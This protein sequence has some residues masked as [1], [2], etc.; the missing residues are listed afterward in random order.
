METVGTDIELPRTSYLGR[1]L[2]LVQIVSAAPDGGLTLSEL[3]AQSGVPASTA[4]RLARLLEEHGL[5]QRL[6]DKRYVAGPGL[7]TLGLRSLR[8]LPAERFHDAVQTLV[9]LTNESVSVGLLFGS[10]ITLVARRE[11][12][13]PLRYVASVGDVI[14]PHR[15]AMGKAILA[16]VSSARREEIMR[17]AVGDQA[18]EVLAELEPELAE[19]IATGVGRDEESFAV[20][21][22]CVAAPI[23]DGGGEAVG[24]ISISGPAARFSRKLADGFLPALREQTRRLSQLPGG[25]LA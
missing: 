21:L 2:G 9:D 16:H 14:A 11:S 17:A 15:S 25:V 4:S 19:T 10:E 18:D 24:A 8:R 5:V 7:L 13:H 1:F 6:P 20:G 23:I 3:A 22:R 12:A